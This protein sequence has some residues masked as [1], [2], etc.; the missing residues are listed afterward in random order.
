MNKIS[1]DENFFEEYYNGINIF[2]VKQYDEGNCNYDYDVYMESIKTDMKIVPKNISFVD[3]NDA[4]YEAF[5]ADLAESKE[6]ALLYC[7]GRIKVSLY[8]GQNDAVVSSPGLQTF[9]NSWSWPMKE[10]WKRVPKEFLKLGGQI[11][12]WKKKYGR[13]QLTIFNNAGHFVPAD[14]PLAFHAYFR[15]WILS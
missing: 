11:V 5:S 15:E 13:L 7:I 8:V 10:G 2:N 6:A 12:G 3:T 9:L 1:D 4:V 14:Q